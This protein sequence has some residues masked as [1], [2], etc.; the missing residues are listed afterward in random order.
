MMSP[1]VDV[2]YVNALFYLSGGPLLT[3]N[4]IINSENHKIIPYTY[5]AGIQSFGPHVCRSPDSPAIFTVNA[6]DIICISIQICFKVDFF[7]VYLFKQRVD[8]YIDWILNHMK[9]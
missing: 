7:L 5:L 4:L 2:T 3:T 1:F 8:R 6:N 9:K